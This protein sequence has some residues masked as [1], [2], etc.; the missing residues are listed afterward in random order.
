MHPCPQRSKSPEGGAK[1]AAL[2]KTTPT[3]YFESHSFCC[4]LAAATPF[5][6]RVTECHCVRESVR[7]RRLLSRRLLSRRLLSPPASPSLA[8][9]RQDVHAIR[10]SL[11]SFASPELDA[12]CRAARRRDVHTFTPSFRCLA[13]PEHG[14]E[15]LGFHVVHGTHFA[16]ATKSS[17]RRQV[18]STFA[19]PS[20][21]SPC[22]SGT[23]TTTTRSPS[24]RFVPAK[25]TE[26]CA[27]PSVCCAAPHL[28]R[29]SPKLRF[30]QFRTCLAWQPAMSS[31]RLFRGRVPKSP[32]QRMVQIWFR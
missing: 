31:A 20:S 17:W 26:R 30:G 5:P 14:A 2:A 15:G 21:T 8:A 32:K 24:I 18:R 12:D 3:A 22:G 27:S 6:A 4:A 1:L 25:W 29:R 11:R 9:R 7:P 23:T 16:Q 19:R 13:R 28:E 10:P